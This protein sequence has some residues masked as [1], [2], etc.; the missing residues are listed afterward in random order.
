MSEEQQK[1]PATVSREDLYRQ[2]WETPVL[3][4][5]ERYGISGNGLKKMCDRLQVPY[6]PLGYWAK[7]RAG[8]S[9]TATPLPDPS[10]RHADAGSGRGRAPP[11]GGGETRRE[12]RER[13][14]Q[15][16]LAGDFLD[17]L[18]KQ[19]PDP[20]ITYDGR[21][22]AEWMTWARDRREA[23]DPLRWNVGDLWTD[24]ASVTAWERRDHH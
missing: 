1:Q 9:V 24:L 5:G 18:E 3:R 20:E 2:V 13:Q 23:F 17:A 10:V 22:A 16:R 15:A 4:L 19:S 6:P 8:K 12:E 21:L 7:L 11:L 14:D